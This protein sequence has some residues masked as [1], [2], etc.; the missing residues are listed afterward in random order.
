MLIRNA[1]GFDIG[2]ALE[3]TNI[4]FDSNIRFKRFDYAGKTRQGGD[5]WNVTLTVHDSRAKGGRRSRSG[6][7]I[8]AACWHAYG[9]F[10]DN[11]PDGTEVISNTAKGRDVEHPGDPWQD[12]NIG[13]DYYPFYYSDACDC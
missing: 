7:R 12:W 5:K 1:T 4:E 11:L 10:R 2:K 13:S 8:A 9:T 3:D 6:R